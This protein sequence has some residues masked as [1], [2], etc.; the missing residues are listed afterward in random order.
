MDISSYSVPNSTKG[1]HKII[2]TIKAT[3]KLDMTM[4]TLSKEERHE[5]QLEKMKSEMGELM[6]KMADMNRDEI[7]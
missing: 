3:L 2:L 4:T 7:K 6:E 5:R 1:K